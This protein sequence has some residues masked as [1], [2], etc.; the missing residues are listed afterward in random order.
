MDISSIVYFYNF[1]FLKLFISLSLKIEI[2][3]EA[4][5]EPKKYT[6]ETKI[7][8]FHFIFGRCPLNEL[9]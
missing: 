4:K 8:S 1:L 5:I 2:I 9:E 6:K 7:L 3:V